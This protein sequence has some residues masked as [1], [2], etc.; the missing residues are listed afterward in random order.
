MCLNQWF[1]L[2]STQIN[3]TYN[4]N[5]LKL[6]FIRTSIFYLHRSFDYNFLFRLG[7]K[8]R[9]LADADEERIAEIWGILHAAIQSDAAEGGQPAGSS[10]VPISA[11]SSGVSAAGATQE[12]TTT[13]SAEP[14]EYP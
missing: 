6:H 9:R 12:P 5:T 3:F 13:P 2:T 1:F 7:E 11:A 14:S 8:G 4:F 10:E